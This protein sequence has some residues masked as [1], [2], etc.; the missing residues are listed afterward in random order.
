MHGWGLKDLF[1]QN[2]F[3]SKCVSCKVLKDLKPKFLWMKTT[4]YPEIVRGK[5]CWLVKNVGF[6]NILH[7]GQ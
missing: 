4:A 5:H 7:N 2:D 1:N 6:K 3:L